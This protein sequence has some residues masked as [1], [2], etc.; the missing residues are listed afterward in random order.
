MR[1]SMFIICV[2]LFCVCVRCAGMSDARELFLSHFLHRPIL[3]VSE[4]TCTSSSTPTSTTTSTSSAC[5]S[6]ADEEYEPLNKSFECD[7]PFLFLVR[8]RP[9]SSKAKPED[10]NE[11]CDKPSFIYFVGT[12][13]KP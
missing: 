12:Y 10:L 8:E 3:E 13:R 2:R 1:C 6:R 4:G 11:E 9:D 5:V 7:R